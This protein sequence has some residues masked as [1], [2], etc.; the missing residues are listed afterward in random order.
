MKAGWVAGSTRARLLLTRRAGPERTRAAA[1]AGSL[2][3][4]ADR[5]AG[6]RFDAVAD[7]SDLETAQRAVAATLLLET[8]IL[9]GWLPAAAGE[10][11]RALA[12]W[13]ELRNIE[14]RLAYLSGQPLTE[15]FALGSLGSAWPEAYRAQSVGE[16]RSALAR[17]VWGDP[18]G[19]TAAD[20]HLGLRLAWT[21]RVAR[22][23]PEAGSWAA[24]A[25]ALIVA[26]ERFLSDRRPEELDDRRTA[27][28]GREW[29]R[30][31]T[32]AD[33]ARLLPARA[34]WA[35]AGVSDPEQLWLCEAAWWR[36]VCGDAEAL[37]HG[38]QE[39]R[40]VVVGAVALLAADAVRT[41][42]A[43][44]AADQGTP[45]AR[46]AFDALG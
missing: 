14:D 32:I 22:T 9:A 42:A 40:A 28:L 29:R 39:G 2:A 6:T 16:L 44:A 5:F 34:A 33:I 30:A 27:G 19:D 37:V 46:E 35:L 18:G 31:A 24:G 13:F 11:I 36:R 21:G 43:L 7:V 20:I 10:E 25:L 38:A 1:G 8:R 45:T 17:S 41:S 4:A 15:P 12:A 3:A 26:R 23:I